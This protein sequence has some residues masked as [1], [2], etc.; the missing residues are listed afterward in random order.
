MSHD[1]LPVRDTDFN[2]C[3]ENSLRRLGETGFLEKLEIPRHSYDNLIPLQAECL[4]CH[5]HFAVQNKK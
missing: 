2:T 1:F 4:L 5:C 3:Q